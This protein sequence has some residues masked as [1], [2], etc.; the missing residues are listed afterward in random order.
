MSIWSQV[1]HAGADYAGAAFDKAPEEHLGIVRLGSMQTSPVA[2]LWRRMGMQRRR[3]TA[4]V[5][6]TILEAEED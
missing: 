1:V 6:F 4:L 5:R 3:S 2:T